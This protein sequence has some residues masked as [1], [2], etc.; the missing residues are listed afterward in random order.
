[1][2][3][4]EWSVDSL[5]TL[6]PPTM[7]VQVI[8][9]QTTMLRRCQSKPFLLMWTWAYI[10]PSKNSPI[11]NNLS[12]VLR[13]NFQI[14]GI[15]SATMVTSIETPAAEMSVSTMVHRTLVYDRLTP[16]HQGDPHSI[17]RYALDRNNCSPHRRNGQALQQQREPVSNEPASID[18]KHAPAGDLK[19]PLHEDPHVEKQHRRFVQVG[20]DGEEYVAEPPVF[21]EFLPLEGV[22][23][24]IVRS[25]SLAHG[26]RP[27]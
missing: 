17:E 23:T 24:E 18:S 11:S 27:E 6:I 14:I 15:G 16:R 21:Q 2:T 9:L 13:C 12:T 7:A 26:I 5:S 22:D 10:A 3:L 20:R 1:M 8:R 4:Q 25:V 19:R